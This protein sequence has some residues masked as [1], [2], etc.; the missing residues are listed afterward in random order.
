MARRFL[1][2]MAIVTVVFATA[3]AGHYLVSW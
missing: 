1:V 3:I 2:L